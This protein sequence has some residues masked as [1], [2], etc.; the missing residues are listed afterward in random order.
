MAP[1]ATQPGNRSLIM[2]RLWPEIRAIARSQTE[3]TSRDVAERVGTSRH[4]PVMAYLAA[5]AAIGILERMPRARKEGR[6]RSDVWRLI[7]DVGAEAPRIRTRT[8]APRRETARELMW[9]TMKVIGVFDVCSL[10]VQASIPGCPVS[11]GSAAA[12]I[13]VLLKPS[14]PYL[15]TMRKAV[16]GAAGWKAQYRLNPRRNTG[17]LPPVAHIVPGT[18]KLASISDA[19]ERRVVWSR[20]DQ[21]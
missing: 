5:L 1:K 10:A 18:S 9:R 15:L 12:F 20:E 3:F 6:Y 13:K 4:A 2:A 17:P 19:N 7:L 21:T 16:S 14:P 11:E 8:G